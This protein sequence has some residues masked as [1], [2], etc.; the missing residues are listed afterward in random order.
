MGVLSV[1]QMPVNV[2]FSVQLALGV[3]NQMC[4]CVCLCVCVCGCLLYAGPFAGVQIRMHVCIGCV[5]LGLGNHAFEKFNFV[6][7]TKVI[8]RINIKY[9]K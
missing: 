7:C 6:C 3:H 4:M 9:C 8:Y 5:L 1:I 2:C